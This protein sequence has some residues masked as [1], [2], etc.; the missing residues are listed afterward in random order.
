[1]APDALLEG[2]RDAVMQQSP[3]ERQRAERWF[4]LRL[5]QADEQSLSIRVEHEDL[6][7]RPAR[8][9]VA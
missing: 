9:G 5:K 6:F 3:S 4:G 2:W 1:M 7:A 8:D